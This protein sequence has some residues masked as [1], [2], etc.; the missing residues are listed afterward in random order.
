MIIMP[1]VCPSMYPQ[2]LNQLV[3]VH[4]IQEGGHA[5]KDDLNITVLNMHLQPL[6]NGDV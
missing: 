4:E 2:L 6:Q 3:D 5:I 1:P